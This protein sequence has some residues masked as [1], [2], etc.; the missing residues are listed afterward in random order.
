[1]L[2]GQKTIVL[3]ITTRPK[4]GTEEAELCI[5]STMKINAIL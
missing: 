4:F 1:M 3:A 5:L 2:E